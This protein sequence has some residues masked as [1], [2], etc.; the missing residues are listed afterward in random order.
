MKRKN[1]EK[2]A[3]CEATKNGWAS[4]AVSSSENDKRTTVLLIPH[5][6]LS[7]WRDAKHTH[8]HKKRKNMKKG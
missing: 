6:S 7:K 3:K 2:S 8:T 5:E 4:A 1:V